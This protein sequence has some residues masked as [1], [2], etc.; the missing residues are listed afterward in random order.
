MLKKNKPFMPSKPIGYKNT[1]S[2]SIFKPKK[3]EPYDPNNKDKKTEFTDITGKRYINKIRL[4]DEAFTQ[5]KLTPKHAEEM[6]KHAHHHTQKH[7]KKMISELNKSKTM[8]FKDAHKIA[9]GLVG[10]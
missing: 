2:S 7:L 3:V 5:D 9:M 1:N 8:S 4:I 6:K 10:I